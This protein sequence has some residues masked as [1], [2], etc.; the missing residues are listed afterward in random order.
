MKLL[1]T[2]LLLLMTVSAKAVFTNT[3]GLEVE[4]NGWILRATIGGDAAGSIGTNGNFFGGFATNNS[5]TSTTALALTVTSMGYTNGAAIQVQRTVYGTKIIRSPF[6]MQNTND[7]Q[8]QDTG[9]TNVVFR[10][11]LSDFIF[12]KDSNI[13]ATALGGWLSGTNGNFTN[14]AA[15]TA[16]AVT[17]SSVQAYPKAIAKWSWPGWNREIGSTMKLRAVGFSWSASV[18]TNGQPL[19]CMRFIGTDE[20]GDA[21]TNTVTT[22][23]LDAPGQDIFPTGE[24][25]GILSQS[26]WASLDAIRCDFQA[27]P[28]IGDSD[29]VLDTTLNLY[30]PPL[31]ASITNLCDRLNVYTDKIAVVGTAGA[32]PAATNVAPA[33]V[34]TANY[35]GSIAAA[36]DSLSVSNLNAHAHGDSGGGLIYI[37]TGI[38]NFA[39]A[40][41]SS[42]RVP[43]AWVTV[44]P[45]P[46]DTNIY[47][48]GD[49]GTDDLNDLVKV[50]N[51]RLQFASTT[52]P[53]SSMKRL[54]LDQCTIASSGSGPFQA[55]E[56]WTTHCVV[57]QL[58]QGFRASS[59]VNNQFFA[60]RGCNLD[61][62][63]NQLN[64]PLV[65]GCYHPTL[66]GRN[67]KVT[68][69]VSS[70]QGSS[71]EF[72]I[73]YNNYFGGF[74][75]DGAAS[76]VNLGDN[77]G[78]GAGMAI[79]QNVFEVAT[80][81]D[82][83]FNICSRNT[84]QFTNILLWHNVWVGKRI[85]GVGYNDSGAAPAYRYQW[86]G[87]NSIYDNTG[88]KSDE[89]TTG[90]GA[91][92]G[93]WPVMWQVG[94]A[95]NMYVESD[96][97]GADAP[98]S[99]NPIFNGLNSY[100]PVG[101]G[102][103]E[104]FFP[105][106]IDRRSQ[107]GAYST[108]PSGGNYRLRRNSPALLQTVPYVMSFDQGGTPRNSGNNFPG[109]YVFGHVQ[110]MI[111]GNATLQ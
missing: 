28:R 57:T 109:A 91:R 14:V 36:N 77:I 96:T 21:V 38:T 84:L 41:V 102:T 8:F 34:S 66:Y 12:Q 61:G 5:L 103:N 71:P 16:R 4:T 100:H 82:S 69:D 90:D 18:Q 35:F 87:L 53:F 2:S 11:S 95:G 30:A 51:I 63:D 22:M 24:Y 94:W 29:A 45:F 80:N 105:R 93:N 74:A 56:M 86:E 73:W 46:G 23:T 52:I 42:N 85:A 44:L 26:A 1:I 64:A 79:I 13:V 9:G 76:V 33:L 78:I 58:T 19:D 48:N 6:P 101:S 62:F 98:G 49:T 75:S 67:Y 27:F 7:I 92:I 10:I 37:K 43:K 3:V 97:T 39:G 111:S 68:S 54:W 81:A 40:T 31:P 17:N 55:G 72:G 65:I 20:S 108:P 106:Y 70:G 83:S 89:H 110:L 50:Q 25:V 47:L 59:I 15:I 88:F 60:L 32:S 104:T 99:F 107:G